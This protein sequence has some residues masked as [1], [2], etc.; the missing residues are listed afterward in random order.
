[1]CTDYKLLEIPLSLNFQRLKVEHFL[2][3][4]GLRLDAVDTYVGVFNADDELVGGGGLDGNIIKCVAVSETERGSGLMACIVS[5]LQSIAAE[6]GQH[7]TMVFTKPEN[8]E[9]FRDLGYTLIAEAPK[10]VLL[11]SSPQQLRDFLST[12]SSLKSP[13]TTISQTGV[14]VMN[15]NPFTRGHQ[16]L[17]ETAAQQ[18]D[19]LVVMVVS[20]N[21]SAFPFNERLAMVQAG[22]AHLDNVTVTETGAYAVSEATFPTYFLKQLSDAAETQMQLDADLFR[23]HIAPALG[24]SVRFVGTEPTDALTQKYNNILKRVFPIIEIERINDISA[25][26]VRAGAWQLVPSTSLSYVLAHYA[27]HALQ[28]ELDLTPKPGLVDRANSGAHKDMNYILMQRSIQ[29]LRPFF[30]QIAEISMKTSHAQENYIAPLIIGLKEIGLKAETAMLAATNGIN[31]HKGALFS[32]GLTIAA[33]ACLIAQERNLS[34]L[35]SEIQRLATQIPEPRSTHG[36]QVR[37]A[38]QGIK[39]A[40]ENARDGYPVAFHAQGS[41]LRLLFQIMSTLDDTNILYR[42]GSD[43]LAEVKQTA[44]RWLHTGWTEKDVEQ[45]DAEFSHRGISP[46]GSADMYA[47]CVFLQLLLPERLTPSSC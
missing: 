32:L 30:Q 25:S 27:C 20:E 22:T 19:Q 12:L 4:Q 34:L 26:K 45:L 33:A 41:G 16:Y 28:A 36:A 7:T 17:I 29:A 31:T 8:R 35:Q 9:I 39:S 23:R 46:G 5:R 13:D 6:H 37:T 43:T 42:C 10:A 40:V 1:M 14:I 38:H 24:A 2:D 11:E 47:L 44:E 3:L 15:A 21:R 18:V